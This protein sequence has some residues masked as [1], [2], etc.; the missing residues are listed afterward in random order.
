MYETLMH[1]LRSF[2][3]AGVMMKSLIVSLIVTI[4]V[5]AANA[6]P[7]FR[8]SLARMREGGGWRGVL[9]GIGAGIFKFLLI[10]LLTRF[11]I[12]ALSYQSRLFGQ[13]HGRVTDRNRSAVLM[14]WGYPH[15][16]RE[17]TVS[18]TRKRTWV[19]RQLK[20]NDKDKRIISESFWEDE[21]FPVQ[22]VD[23]Q[24][25]AIVS[26]KEEVKDYAV[27]QKSIVS[28]DVE[29]ELRDNPR[30]LG[31]ANYAGY[32]DLWR[33]KY[34]VANESQW[35][36]TAHMSFAL[37]ARNGLFDEMYLR[38]D[39]KDC[40]DRTKSDGKAVRWNVT[41][42]PGSTAR[43]E[44]G[45]RSRGLEHLRYIPRRMSQTGHYRVAVTVDGIP[46]EKLDYPIGSM[47]PAEELSDI[48]AMPYT[49]TW[50][51]DNA[52]TSYDIG[53][54]LPVAEQ[55]EYHFA[56]LLAEAPVGLVLLFV[57]LTMPRIILGRPVR[58]ELITVLG[59]G[60]CLHYTFMGRLADVLPGFLW[61]FG[62]SAAVLI[63]VIGWLRINDDEPLLS[64]AIEVAAFVF[65]V[66]LYPLAVVDAET[67]AL[68]MQLFYLGILTLCCVLLACCR[69]SR[70]VPSGN[71][72]RGS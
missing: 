34:V 6:C 65:L 66:V 8:T 56:R 57:L 33:L 50:K 40:L 35:R 22:A 26:V 38:V 46:P 31:N 70:R 5:L 36:T 55:P 54:K 53:I 23:G 25:P 9:A 11:F 58:P 44:I 15:E 2:F 59:A 63:A 30:R 24:M 39:E 64:R 18:H 61:P 51:L 37:P 67:T 21:E 20:L 43:V 62:V 7:G 71:T 12:T 32:D 16:Q 1:T 19:T 3:G 42:P 14:K 41:M 49:L 45:Y 72:S 60:Y 48:T 13:Q 68:W 52:L 47:P 28:A 17:I 69:I 4:V 27:E 10:F 29:I